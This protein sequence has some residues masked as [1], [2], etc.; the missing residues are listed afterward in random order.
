MGLEGKEE[1]VPVDKCLHRE[2]P[3]SVSQNFSGQKWEV[4]EVTE[5]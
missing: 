2:L 5:L 1:R 4:E 3:V